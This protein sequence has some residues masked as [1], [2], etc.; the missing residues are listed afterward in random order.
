M[1]YGNCSTGYGYSPDRS[2]DVDR[3]NPSIQYVKNCNRVC[4]K[5]KYHIEKQNGPFIESYCKLQNNF[6]KG[7]DKNPNP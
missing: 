1:K 5:C 7:V 6:H 4:H 3:F 2:K